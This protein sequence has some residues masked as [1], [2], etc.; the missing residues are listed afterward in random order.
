MRTRWLEGTELTESRDP[1]RRSKLEVLCGDGTSILTLC[2]PSGL[3]RSC[4][5][6]NRYLPLIFHPMLSLLAHIPLVHHAQPFESTAWLSGCC[7]PS[8][9][10]DGPGDNCQ[11]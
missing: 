5:P 11:G 4:P 3:L 6:R 10:L 1:L 9:S 8:I 7:L 2:R